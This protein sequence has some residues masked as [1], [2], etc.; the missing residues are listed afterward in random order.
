[1]CRFVIAGIIISRAQFLIKAV[2]GVLAYCVIVTNKE[3]I[4]A[5]LQKKLPK[6]WY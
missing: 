3:E 4:E 2:A 5:A 6:L 1:M